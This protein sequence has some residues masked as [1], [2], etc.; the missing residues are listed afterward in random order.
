MELLYRNGKKF[1]FQIW[2]WP[3]DLLIPKSIEVLLGS[4][5][6]HVWS[7]ISVCQKEMEFSWVNGKKFEVQI[8]PWPFDPKSIEAL[9]RSCV[10]YHHGKSKGKGVIM[11]KAL[12]HIQTD[13]W[14]DG[15]TDRQTA[16]V[17]PVHPH[18]FG[19]GVIKISLNNK[20][21]IGR[22]KIGYLNNFLLKVP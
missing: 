8:W 2:P 4:W 1:E 9:L 3:L 5:S 10:K 14:T 16:M 20:N 7:I 15:W 6:T 12:F 18:S 21:Y 11:Q 17:K 19:G 13:G 22:Q